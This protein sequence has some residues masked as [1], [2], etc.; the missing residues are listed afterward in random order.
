MAVSADKQTHAEAIAKQEC[1]KF[2]GTVYFLSICFKVF[3]IVFQITLTTCVS[4]K[5]F[6]SGLQE[7]FFWVAWLLFLSPVVVLDTSGKLHMEA[8]V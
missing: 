6:T 7:A 8:K 3:L 2:R 4:L 5:L 1:K